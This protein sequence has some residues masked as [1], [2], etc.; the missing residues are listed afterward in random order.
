MSDQTPAPVCPKCGS[1]MEPGYLLDQGYGLLDQGHGKILVNRWATGEPHPSWLFGL[2]TEDQTVR[3]VKGWR[4]TECGF[5]E[6]YAQGMS[7]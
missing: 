1:P 4:C 2:R 5:L 7:K 6:M 3:E